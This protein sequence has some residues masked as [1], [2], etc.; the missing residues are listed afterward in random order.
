MGYSDE[1]TENMR[2]VIHYLEV[3]DPRIKL[4]GGC[5]ALCGKCPLDRGGICKS[6]E[7]VRRYDDLVLKLCG[8]RAGTWMKWSDFSER[9]RAHILKPNRLS[10]ICSDCEWFSNC[11]AIEPLR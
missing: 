11:S 1:F 3:N 2:N 4:L 5:D 10:E 7:K 6:A 8:I 9:I